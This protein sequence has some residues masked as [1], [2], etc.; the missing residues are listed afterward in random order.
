MPRVARYRIDAI[1]DLLRQ[2]EY[3]PPRTRR[4]QMNAAERLVTEIDPHHN[5]PLD[6]VVFRVTG[7]RGD[8]A[9]EPLTFMGEALLPDLVNLV[10]QLSHGLDLPADDAGRRA[11]DL[12]EVARR[13]KVSA[14]TLG[15]YRKQGLVCHY[16]VF[17]DGGRRLACFDDA[18][19]RFLDGHRDR[20]ER[21]AGFSRV[22]G[23]IERALI[24]EA[25]TMRRS[26]GL[27]LNEAARRL[28][29]KH[30][31]AHETVRGILRRYGQRSGDADFI[32]RGPLGER[33][34]RVIFRAARFGVPPARI[35]RRWG[36]SRAA[37]HRAINRGRGER[38]RGLDLPY[39]NLPTFERPDAAAVI[40]SAPAV[41]ANL[42]ERLGHD[43]AADLIEAARAAS[44]PQQDLE[45]ALLAGY[46]LLK[47]RARD[48]IGDLP[49]RPPSQKLDLIETDLR[50]AGMLKAR[51]V[52]LAFP[53]ALRTIE[54]NLHR[55]LVEQP[56]EDIVILIRVGFEVI[57][58]TVEAID[59]A[60]GQRLERRCGF[61]VDRALAAL[62]V[63]RRI[64]RAAARHQ[65]GSLGLPDL[66]GELNPWQA[67]LAPRLDLLAH[68]ECL[69][70][71]LHRAVTLR[72]GLDGTP[73]RSYPA[74]AAQL[75]VSPSTAARLVIKAERELRRLARHAL[76]TDH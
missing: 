31:R 53:A 13:L 23:S 62:G 15:R 63:C 68:R 25:R 33:D 59:P 47:R 12:S 43:D 75:D 16:V 10:Q 58:R 52:C 8:G 50:W 65:P 19:Q 18:L 14:K 67:W 29:R 27:A 7:Y 38:L 51:L 21:A 70:P 40:L 69:D 46:N 35:A 73:P 37:I 56:A 28:A 1:G 24:D 66:L 45:H 74:L 61:A 71:A 48:A 11:G 30:G 41:T 22:D 9:Q 64:S 72:W 39:V 60:R 36:K 5:Y 17:P 26:L 32:D 3:A 34:R 6:F 49:L 55:P 54:R 20:L 44:S 57:A 76:I 42:D 4:R 2:L